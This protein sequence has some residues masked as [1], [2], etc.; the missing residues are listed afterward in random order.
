MHYRTLGK[1]G[2]K[3]SLMGFGTGGPGGFGGAGNLTPSQHSALIRR[4]LSLGVNLFDTSARYGESEEIL[5]R[6]LA[7]VRRDS[8]LLSTKWS[9]AM[10]WSPPGVG[11]EDGAVRKDPQALAEGVDSSL[12]RLR[13]DYIDIMLLHGLRVEQYEEVCERF[14][15]VMK[16]LQEQ[17]KIRFIGLSER[18]I[19]DPAHR[20]AALA[21]RTHPALWDVVMLKY[22]ILNQYAAKEALP[23]ALEHGV[24]VMNMASVRVKLTRPERLRELVA[25]WKRRSLIGAGSLPDADPLGW[26]VHD[27]VDSVISAGYKFAADHPAVSTVLTGTTNT[28]HLEVNAAA[29]ERPYLP[30]ADRRRLAELFGEI[31]EHA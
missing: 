6:S 7:G 14:C 21:L 27:E 1:T 23:L 15:P 9:H 19:A 26:L 25:D 16:R 3:V 8:Y 12:R 5:G 4:C 13:T 18:F 10:A 22:G 11:G 28:G 31:A 24:G 17:G 29:L 30:E 2:L 20:A